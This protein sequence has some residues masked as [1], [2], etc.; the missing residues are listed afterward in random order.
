MRF[1]I[2]AA[3][4]SAL[5][6]ARGYEG[7]RQSLPG[8]PDRIRSAAAVYPAAAAA[9]HLRGP[10]VMRLTVGV[11]GRVNHAAL[12]RGD[13][14]LV[15]AAASAARGWT[16]TPRQTTVGVIAG[17][18]IEPPDLDTALTMSPA[19]LVDPH[20]TPPRRGM[21]GQA[22]ILMTIGP[23]G[24]VVD[25]FG[26]GDREQVLIEAIDTAL[27]W[28]TQPLIVNGTPT[29]YNCGAEWTNLGGAAIRVGSGI[30]R[31][32]ECYQPPAEIV[33]DSRPSVLELLIDA[34]GVVRMATVLR[35]GSAS[36]ED[37]VTAVKQW[38]FGPLFFNGASI[39]TIQTATF[40]GQPHD[41]SPVPD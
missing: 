6:V 9:R 12:V 11:D 38:R 34:E 35:S 16:F 3:L 28:H 2:S 15:S 31:R 26:V 21:P 36:Y 14:V 39:S 17:V 24:R 30:F 7:G 37:A 33:A 19:P 22:R 29:L 5:T 1:A 32:A 8:P 41:H 13:G 27:R 18:N 4:L 40:P 25:A 23:T 10:V 20:S